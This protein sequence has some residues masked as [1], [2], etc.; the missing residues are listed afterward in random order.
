[1]RRSKEEIQAEALDRAR[2]GESWANYPAIIEGFKEKGIPE[3]EI[4]PRVNT[5]TLLAWNAL[6]RKVKRGEHGVRVLTYR[7]FEDEDEEGKPKTRSTP[8]Y[9]TVFHVSQT[10]EFNGKVHS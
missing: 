9:S 10:E 4:L 2:N 3:E 7:Q 5:L 6:G 1:M 8:W